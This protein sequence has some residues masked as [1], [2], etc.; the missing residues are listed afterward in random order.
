M[1]QVRLR[2][3]L[4]ENTPRAAP[5]TAPR[6]SHPAYRTPSRSQRPVPH[7]VPQPAPSPTSRPAF[8]RLASSVSEIGR[9]VLVGRLSPPPNKHFLTYFMSGSRGAR[10]CGKADTPGKANTQG[11]WTP[12]E[13]GRHGESGCR[14]MRGHAGPH[15]FGVHAHAQLSV[16]PKLRK[17]APQGG[18]L[19]VAEAGLEPA[20]SRL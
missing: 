10:C 7:P 5:R 14:G 9:K 20:T 16:H 2:G 18:V 6:A 13:G 17:N 11:R 3:G 15:A 4:N 19:F 1:S 8:R 12:R